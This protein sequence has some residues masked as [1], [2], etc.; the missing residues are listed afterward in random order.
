MSILLIRAC[1]LVLAVSVA[2]RPVMATEVFAE[3]SDLLTFLEEECTN[4][5][6]AL[7]PMQ[8]K[9]LDIDPKYVARNIYTVFTTAGIAIALL[10]MVI[11]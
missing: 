3:Y 9:C 2:V 6:S 1:A 8:L 10:L 4:I 11:T 7:S 5:K